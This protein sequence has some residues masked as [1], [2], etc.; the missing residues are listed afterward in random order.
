M[1]QHMHTLNKMTQ[2]HCFP[3]MH[4][5]VQ[6]HNTSSTHHSFTHIYWL[7]QVL[8]YQTKAPAD[9]FDYKSIIYNVECRIYFQ[10]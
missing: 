2:D 1:T 5:L 7:Q 3:L 9:Q 8:V 10:T 6:K 4:R